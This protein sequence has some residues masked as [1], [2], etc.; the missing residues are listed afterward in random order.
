MN[1][2]RFSSLSA[3][4]LVVGLLA[5]HSIAAPDAGSNSKESAPLIDEAEK[6]KAEEPAKESAAPAKEP[7]AQ[8]AAQ[9][10]QAKPN[11]EP[12]PAKEP[13]NFPVVPTIFASISTIAFIILAI[14]F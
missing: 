1:T 6:P 8:Q 3:I 11:C 7:Q 2:I 13:S 4:A 10:A 14:I 9:P 12:A 5:C